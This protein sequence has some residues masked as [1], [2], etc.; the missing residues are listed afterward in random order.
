MA[1]SARVNAKFDGLQSFLR[2]LAVLV[3]IVA[4]LCS[5]ILAISAPFYLGARYSCGV[6][7]EAMGMNWSY[8]LWQD[9]MIVV[10]GRSIPI[11]AYKVVKVAP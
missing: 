1:D 11:T 8:G 7:A 2:G 4:A 3:I 5:F 9:C 6:Q 10:D